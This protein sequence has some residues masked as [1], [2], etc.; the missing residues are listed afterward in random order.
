M[1]KL[2]K[3]EKG[4]MYD[5]HGRGRRRVRYKATDNGVTHNPKKAEAEKKET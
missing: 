3:Q 1:G 5:H 2:D 4:Y